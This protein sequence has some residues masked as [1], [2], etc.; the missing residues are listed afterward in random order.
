MSILKRFNSLQVPQKILCI[1]F[2]LLLFFSTIVAS[3]LAWYS[4]QNELN[5]FQGF[6]PPVYSVILQKYE[7]DVAGNETT[8]PIENA[9]FYL[10]QIQDDGSETQI[11]G[12]YIT[13][14]D[15]QIV[16]NS[17][18]RPG[19]YY[20]LE[21]HP[22]YGYDFDTKDGEAIRKYYFTITGDTEDEEVIVHAYNQRLVGDLRITKEVV[23]NDGSI[24]DED[25]PTLFVF[26]VTFNDEGAY[27]YSVDGVDN[28]QLIK[29]GGS[30]YLAHGQT[31]TI[32]GL[33]VGVQYKV[34]EEVNANYVIR[35][36]NHQGNITADGANVSFVNTY[37]AEETG[38]LSIQ[39]NVHGDG[40]NLHKEFDFTVFFSDG[41]S[42]VYRIGNGDEQIVSSGGTITLKHGQVATFIDLPFGLEYT[43]TEAD[44]SQDGYIAT[45]QEV[46]G[47]VIREV[48]F[49]TFDNVF[50]KGYETGLLSISKHVV[51]VDEID[52]AKE[53]TFTVRFSEVGLYTYT[54]VND[55]T[56]SEQGTEYTLPE[57][58]KITLKH[59]QTA[60]FSNLPQG[61][62]YTVLE[63]ETHG[64]VGNFKEV[65]GVIAGNHNV[66]ANFINLQIPDAEQMQSTLSILKLMDGDIPSGH[67]DKEFSFTIIIDGEETEFNLQ[68]GEEKVFL[69]PEGAMY[70]VLEKDY[71]IDGYALVSIINGQGMGEGS[72]IQVTVTNRFMERVD[73]EVDVV[74]EWRGTESIELPSSITVHL[75]NGDSIV[76]SA[77]I[78]PDAQGN[79]KHTFTAPKY[80]LE[81]NEIQYTVHEEE[82]L[83][84]D[85]TM[86]ATDEGYRIINTY[87]PKPIDVTVSKLW[88][89]NDVNRP[90]SIEVQLYNNGEVYGDVVIL[91]EDNNWTYTWLNM[92]SD[93]TWSVDE[94]V[95]PIGYKSSIS[96]NA[97]SGFI[98][99]NTYIE[100]EEVPSIPGDLGG[101]ANTTNQPSGSTPKTG[102]F[103][104]IAPWLIVMV[105]SVSALR[106]LL[107]HK[108][109]NN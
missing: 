78:T 97:Q 100:P 104:T 94:P 55:G 91:N 80:D 42:Y 39:K 75:K 9:E 4:F 22:G 77:M 48:E 31:A 44:Y 89:G 46:Q 66:N 103:G 32:H 43:V 65:S 59:G 82:I 70:E 40:A 23:T 90:E 17:T 93:V 88:R 56:S 92:A 14:I 34:T 11:G 24:V 83:N 3:T 15:G 76:D 109:K 20:F 74:K 60:I 86:E 7:R 37:K 13:D 36:T 63:N 71:S 84:Y 18:L 105:I 45:I 2:S 33:P 108:K 27:R 8:I 61:L 21:T 25:W 79:W 52:D 96:G 19:E 53:F 51:S 6:S 12:R 58:G 54:V 102:D 1:I 47:E 69:L 28:E 62:K 106:Y 64:Y 26:N 57:D 29:S 101:N 99:I 81:G 95:V 98:I 16:L 68:H 5:S 10:Y 41:G 35:S 67:E 50:E 73:I 38:S 107:F 72:A 87:A 49:I 85:V 30:I